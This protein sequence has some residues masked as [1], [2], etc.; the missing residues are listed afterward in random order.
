MSGMNAITGR[1]VSGI[2]HLRQSIRILL[3][4]AVGSRVM[5]REFGAGVPDLVDAPI[6]GD[7]VAEVYSS[8]VQA[9]FNFEP[10]FRL[11]A[12]YVPDITNGKITLDLEG[13]Y[14]GEHMRLEGLEL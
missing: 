2:D 6:N 10:R 4:T 8:V 14:L 7:F 3:T 11:L 9:L 13:E 1:R 12:V 5:R